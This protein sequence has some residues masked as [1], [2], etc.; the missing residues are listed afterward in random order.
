MVYSIGECDHANVCFSCCFRSRVLYNDRL[1][2]ICRHNN[3]TVV[4]TKKPAPFKELMKTPFAFRF[5]EYGVV[6]ND[7][8]VYKYLQFMISNTCRFCERK[9][10][11]IDQLNEHYKEIH[12]VSFCPVCLKYQ[13]TFTYDKELFTEEQLKQHFEEVD[14]ETLV[15][16]H[17]VCEFC[18]IPF[19]DLDA[20][21]RHLNSQHESC[22]ICDKENPNRNIRY[23]NTYN[24]LYEHMK[25]EHYVCDDPSCVAKHY[26]AFKTLEELKLHR[27]VEHGRKGDKIILESGV[28]FGNTVESPQTSDNRSAQGRRYRRRDD[29]AQRVMAQYEYHRTQETEE[30]KKD[31]AEDASFSTT[32][33]PRL[34]REV[35]DS[36]VS[37]ARRETRKEKKNLFPALGSS[38]TVRREEKVPVE[39]KEPAKKKKTSQ[40]NEQRIQEVLGSSYEKYIADAVKYRSQDITAEAFL[41][42]CDSYFSGAA[43]RLEIIAAIISTWPSPQQK[44]RLIEADNHRNEERTM[45]RIRDEMCMNAR[46]WESEQQKRIKQKMDRQVIPESER[47]RCLEEDAAKKKNKRQKEQFPSLIKGL[48][49]P[50]PKTSTESWSQIARATSL[51]AQR[52]RQERASK[53]NASFNESMFPKLGK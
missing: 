21:Y 9:F 42:K 25:A 13:K 40:T 23:Y 2:P 12:H 31:N 22:Y 19:Y 20:L 33:F 37:T 49:R 30:K 52:E 4:Y 51:D 1:C 53:E 16:R 3:P 6:T 45:L 41:D 7:N 44:N 29:G 11:T 8:S 24:D 50:V 5:K 10:K 14:P 32:D 26:V 39:R 27:I 38:T 34:G 35:P 28:Y 17:P 36:S 47:L 46:H 48:N 43:D 18:D 15:T